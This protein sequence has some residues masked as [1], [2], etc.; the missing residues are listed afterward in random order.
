MTSP[1]TGKEMVLVKEKCTLKFRNEDFEI[2]YH[3]Y[4]CV[5]S[6]ESFTTNEIDDINLQQVYEQYM[7]K[8]EVLDI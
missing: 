7:V 1:V 5:V 6:G 4:K 3:S 8:Y 2:I